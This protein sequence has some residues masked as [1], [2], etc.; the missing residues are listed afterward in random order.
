MG[1]K[2]KKKETYGSDIKLSSQLKNPDDLLGAIGAEAS[3]E[4]AGEGLTLA[5]SSRPLGLDSTVAIKSSLIL[6]RR[7]ERSASSSRASSP[8]TSLS[9]IMPRSSSLS[10]AASSS[11]R[12]VPLSGVE[13]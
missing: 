8:E 1:N 13:G 4:G 5:S 9:S 3:R 12:D 10:S 11:S 7:L 6:P 2:R